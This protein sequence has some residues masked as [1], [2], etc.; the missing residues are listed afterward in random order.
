MS[1]ESMAVNLMDLQ[2]TIRQLQ[3]QRRQ[4]DVAIANLEDLQ[5]THDGGNFVIPSR[6]GRKSMGPEER[7]QVSDRIRRYWATRREQVRP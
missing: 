2:E 3:I 6:R 7:Q 4:I 1:A 5:G